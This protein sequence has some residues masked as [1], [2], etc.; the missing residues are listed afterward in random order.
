MHCVDVH[1]RKAVST[2]PFTPID[3]GKELG[4]AYTV[5]FWA[6]TSVG[7]LTSNGKSWL[8]TSPSASDENAVSDG[9]LTHVSPTK[10]QI[11]TTKDGNT[12]VVTFPIPPSFQFDPTKWNNYVYTFHGDGTHADVNLNGQSPIRSDI[13][14]SSGSHTCIRLANAP[15][16]TGVSVKVTDISM[17]EAPLPQDDIKKVFNDG[18]IGGAALLEPLHYFRFSDDDLMKNEGSSGSNIPSDTNII[19]SPELPVAA[20]M[21]EWKL[22]LFFII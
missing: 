15:L 7:D 17:F 22:L 6:Q 18:K 2:I 21:D 1:V 13:P 11:T 8:A 12:A 16:G 20:G 5:S 10:I 14:V 3:H 4:P 19:T 9:L